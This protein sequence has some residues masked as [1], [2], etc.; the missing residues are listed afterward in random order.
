MDSKPCVCVWGKGGDDEEQRTLKTVS[1]RDEWEAERL[2]T[3]ES[4]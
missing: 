4:D 3:R 1:K 2:Q